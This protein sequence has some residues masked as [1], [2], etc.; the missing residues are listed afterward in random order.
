MITVLPYFS[1]IRQKLPLLKL[2][3]LIEQLHVSKKDNGPK[4]HYP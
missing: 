3:A 4:E 1:K 2:P